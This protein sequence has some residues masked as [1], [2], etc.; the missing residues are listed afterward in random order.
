MRLLV[1][2]SL[3]VFATSCMTM[4]IVDR[5]TEPGLTKDYARSH[6]MWGTGTAVVKLD[7]PN[8]VHSISEGH[9]FG[10]SVMRGL[11]LG[12]WQ[13]STARVVCAK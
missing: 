11:T 1:S 9:T 4:K 8:G 5:K 2:A 12:I 7:C 13:P 10:N 3:A 6:W